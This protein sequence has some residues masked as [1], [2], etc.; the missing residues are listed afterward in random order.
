MTPVAYDQVKTALSEL[1]AEAEESTNHNVRLRARRLAGSSASA[2]SSNNL[3]F[4]GSQLKV[5][6]K[7]NRQEE[8][9][10]F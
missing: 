6:Y 8:M 10:T 1:Q 7:R 2:S 9:E 5:P 4:T 3:V